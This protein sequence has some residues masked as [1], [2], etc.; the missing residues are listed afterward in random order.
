MLLLDRISYNART[1]PD[2]PAVISGKRRLTYMELE[3]MSDALAVEIGRRAAAHEAIPVIGH[4]DPLMHICFLACAK[5]GHAYCPIDISLPR[6]RVEDIL[7]ALDGPPALIADQNA[8]LPPENPCLSYDELTS[9]CKAGYAERR[10]GGGA[11]SAA[12]LAED[13]TFYII[14]TSGSTGKP[15][16]VEISYGA[17]SRFAD[18]S[19]SLAGSAGKKAGAV[20]LNQAPYSFDLSVMDTYTALAAGGTVFC[21]TGGVQREMASLLAALRE[22]GAKYW[23]STP[24]FA[25]L[26]LA[27]RKFDGEL[28]PE[29]RAFIFCGERLGTTTARRLR[30]RFGKAGIFNTYGPTE[31]TVAVTEAEISD[32]M[33]ASG[34]ELPIGRPRPGTEIDIDP[35]NGE[36][37]I[38][39]NTLS[40]GYYRDPARTA[41]AFFTDDSGRRCYRSGDTGRLSG[42]LLYCGGRLDLQIKLHGYRIELGDIE[43]NLMKIAGINAAAA[44]PET[45]DGRVRSL[46]AY[47]VT[48]NSG[49]DRQSVRDSLS[50]LLPAY[51][52]PKRIVFT[53]ALP[54]TAN[55]KTDRRALMSGAGG[56]HR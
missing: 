35:L 40:K 23:V 20:F 56:G 32:D 1:A 34:R 38:S 49:L 2:R 44:V 47:I 33:I 30:Q 48:D 45:R 21:L 36:M 13:D 29:L 37:I 55:G 10:A 50:K 12:A 51:M 16:G 22:S 25:D 8:P 43:Q 31:S 14:F 27:D 7:S 26:C 46:T 3:L 17:L 42:G 28:M 41:G 18:W 39:G 53:D 54:M 19:L 52:V 4:K 11:G 5:S 15:K 6:E 9:L 24:S